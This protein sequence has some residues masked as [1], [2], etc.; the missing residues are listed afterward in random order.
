MSNLISFA[1]SIILL[2]YYINNS[3]CFFTEIENVNILFDFIA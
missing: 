1:I 2:I 3:S